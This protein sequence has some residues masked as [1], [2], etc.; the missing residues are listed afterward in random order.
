MDWDSKTATTSHMRTKKLKQ[1]Q[2]SKKKKSVQGASNLHPS[3]REDTVEFILARLDR[4]G[5][6]ESII[7]LKKHRNNTTLGGRNCKHI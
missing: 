2:T 4:S 5:V 7:K 6:H 1:T 3:E